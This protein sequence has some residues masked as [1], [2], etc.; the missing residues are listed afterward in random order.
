M[1]VLLAACGRARPEPDPPNNT[2]GS[3]TRIGDISLHNVYVTG[4]RDGRYTS[5]EQARVRLTLLNRGKQRDALTKVSSERASTASLHWDRGCDGKAENV[6][7]IVVS[8]TGKVPQDPLA[9]SAVPPSSETKQK[10]RL[11]QPY[12]ITLTADTEIRNGTTVPITFTFRDAG[13]VTLE[14]IVQSRHPKDQQSEFACLTGAA[15]SP[16]SAVAE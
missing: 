16:S 7:A 10:D 1:L 15:P 4:A 9:E 13:T 6:D 3:T 12:F 8:A 2:L 14:A 11:H 5:G